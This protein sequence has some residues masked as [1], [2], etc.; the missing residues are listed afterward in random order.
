M[1]KRNKY[2]PDFKLQVVKEYSDLSLS[3]IA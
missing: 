3:D 1:K 2:S